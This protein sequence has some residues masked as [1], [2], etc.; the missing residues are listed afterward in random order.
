MAIQT[1]G[2]IGAGTM[3]NGIAQACAASGI[4]AVMQD[5]SDAPREPGVNT[6]SASLDQ[7]IIKKRPS[8]PNIRCRYRL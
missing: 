2:I 4:D 8:P 3:G 5:V 7:Y 6:L 1:V